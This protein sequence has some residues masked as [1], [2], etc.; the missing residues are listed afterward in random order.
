MTSYALPCTITQHDSLEL[1]VAISAPLSF[2]LRCSSEWFITIGLSE[3]KRARKATEK[4]SEATVQLDENEIWIQDDEENTPW[5][6]PLVRPRHGAG[7][8]YSGMVLTWRRSSLRRQHMQRHFGRAKTP[9]LCI[10]LVVNWL[11]TKSE[12][13]SAQDIW[14]HPR[15]ARL[16]AQSLL[17]SIT[18]IKLSAK[19]SKPDQCT[20]SL[21]YD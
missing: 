20:T 11:V 14:T 1:C 10:E 12:V 9:Q 16:A 15:L 8:G 19:R 18:R 17:V 21:R 2:L 13:K 4:C 7:S 3:E 6:R 5:G